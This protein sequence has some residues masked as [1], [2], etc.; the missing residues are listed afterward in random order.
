MAKALDQSEIDALFSKAQAT[1]KTSGGRS[2]R[3]IVPCDLRQANQLRADQLVAVTTLHESL[4]R[5]LSSSLGAQF[6]VA[7]E[8]NLVSAEQLTYKEFT[9]RLPELTYFA[10]LHVMPIDARAAIQLDLALAYPI[11]DVVLGGVGAAA[12][13]L[14]DLTEIEEQVLETVVRQIVQDLQ[15][16]WASVLDLDFQFEQR[17]RSV[18]IQSMMLPQEKVLCLGFETKLSEASGSLIMVFPAVVA[19]ALLRKL[20]AQWSYSERIPSRESRRRVR[21]HLLECRFATD[22]SLPNSPLSVRQLINLEPGQVLTLPVRVREPIH[23]NVGGKPMFL[24]YPVRQG[25]QRGAKVEKRVSILGPGT[26]K[27]E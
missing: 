2:S 6:R 8:M 12:T 21:E 10:A 23:F 13:N 17:Q 19:N 22:L 15:G 11:V 1:R 26:K 20:S 16:T 4:A 24:A 25:T 18:Q 14:R 9:T 7:F 3:K 27:Q 5:R